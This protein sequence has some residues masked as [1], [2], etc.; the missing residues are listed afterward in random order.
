MTPNGAV[1]FAA[2]TILGAMTSGSRGLGLVYAAIALFSVVE[3]GPR[4]FACLRRACIVMVPL[5]T[6]MLIIWVGIVGR[7][8]Q[9]IA[10]GTDGSRGAALLYVVTV[11]ARLFLIVYLLQAV[12][13]RFD[14]ITPFGFVRALNLPS[15]VKRQI[16]LTLSLI[17][18]L[19]NA[20]D[21]A[22]TALIAAGVVTRGLS[23]RN[24]ATG[25]ILVQ[26]V[27][28]T[29]ITT[30]TARMRDKWPIEDTLALL[31][32]TLDGS[33]KR[34]SPADW[35]WLVL[36]AFAFAAGQYLVWSHA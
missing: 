20:V 18:T 14:H 24:L 1:L 32:P 12:L 10:A 8:P 3:I 31:G 30:V 16:I 36:A 27:W 35:R 33:E 26:T 28:L 21:R 17:E 34:L 19:R 29:A 13:Q 25:W 2:L 23:L 22:H 15:G 4:A 6:F 9:E 7:S 5:A 11:A